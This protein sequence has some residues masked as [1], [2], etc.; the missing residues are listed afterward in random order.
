MHSCFNAHFVIHFLFLSGLYSAFFLSDS[1]VSSV[2]PPRPPP[3]PFLPFQVRRCPYA[4]V[5]ASIGH[6]RHL[7]IQNK[8]V[9]ISIVTNPLFTQLN[10]HLKGQF[11]LLS[12]LRTLN[13]ISIISF[14]LDAGITA[15][16]FVGYF[17]LF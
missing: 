10:S 8:R 5:R 4:Y 1:K 12:W 2:P 15:C 16:Y 14:T 3:P 13:I 9:R 7:G 6:C 17:V 11:S